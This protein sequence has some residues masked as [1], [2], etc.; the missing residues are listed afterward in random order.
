MQY[1][2]LVHAIVPAPA[3]SL[4]VLDDDGPSF[5]ALVEGDLAA[6]VSLWPAEGTQALARKHAANPQSAH[7]ALLHALVPDSAVVPVKFATV[8]AGEIHVR[9]LLRD[10]TPLVR[11]VLATVQGRR[12]SDLTVTW[13][14]EAVL[15]Q[16]MHHPTVA[17]LRKDVLLGPSCDRP[18]QVRLGRV[19]KALL[20]SRRASLQN[21]LLEPLDAIAYRLLAFASA[22]E[23]VVLHASLL[24]TPHEEDLLDALLGEVSQE[25]GGN[26]GFR[27]DGPQAPYRFT[28][29]AA[30]PLDAAALE[31]ARHLLNLD[32]TTTRRAIDVA[33]RHTLQHLNHTL[34][35][36]T[37]P[38][39]GLRMHE[40][41]Q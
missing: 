29:L 13:N 39:F 41:K 12:Q 14:A 5:S 19:V 11:E 1:R 23:A 24:L 16:L 36:T 35:T 37:D 8:V 9:R 40:L 31:A 28:T 17:N 15:G 7:A 20:E 34:R 10:A 32:V 4:P 22:D 21:A 26:L 18:P 30:T 25:V 2:L 38:A 27:V 3:P 33:Y 6:I